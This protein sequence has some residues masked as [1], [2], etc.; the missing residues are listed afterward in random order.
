MQHLLNED[1]TCCDQALFRRGS[2][3]R[4]TLESKRN[5]PPF[6]TVYADGFGGQKSFGKKSIDGAI[7]A[8]VFVCLG[9]GTIQCK[10]YSSKAQFCVLLKR[11]FIQVEALDYFVRV[12]VLDGAGENTSGD[13]EDVCDARIRTTRFS[14]SLSCSQSNETAGIS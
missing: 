14:S 6:H 12:L 10:P 13:I 1:C 8:F 2:F 4:N 7:G 11:F 5:F 3:P 9:T